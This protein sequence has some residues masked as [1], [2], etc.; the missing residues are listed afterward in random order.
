VRF[1]AL[2]LLVA[3]CSTPAPEV[4]AEAPVP[5][6]FAPQGEVLL[7]VDGHPVYE[8]QVRLALDLLTPEE[9]EAL[10]ASG[11]LKQVVARM[12]IED[13]YYQKAVAAKLH[14]DPKVQLKM[15]MAVRDALARA[16]VEHEVAPKLTEEALRKAY[17]DHAVAFAAPEA[18]IRL[19]LL[20]DG[21]VAKDLWAKLQKGEAFEALAKKHSIDR[22]MGAKGGEW[23][24]VEQGKTDLAPEIVASVFADGA[25]GPREP[26][27]MNGAWILVDVEERRGQKP[28]EEIRDQLAS[29]LERQAHIEVLT[30]AEAAAKVEWRK[31]PEALL[32]APATPAPEAATAGDAAPAQASQAPAPAQ[33]VQ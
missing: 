14:E 32:G 26:I 33:P 19:I 29:Q 31:E 4:V 17:A 1:P 5:G 8:D 7:T 13:G 3:A 10:L 28:F 11:N 6:A 24:W 22:S 21:K 2:A 12:G 20:T 23:G 9:R 25:I 30:A 16:W 27:S 15:A 18:R